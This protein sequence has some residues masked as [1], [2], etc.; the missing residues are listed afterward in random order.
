MIA[1]DRN[2]HNLAPRLLGVWTRFETIMWIFGH[3]VALTE[4]LRQRARQAELYAKGRTEL[5][6]YISE[7]HPKGLT[8]TN[9]RPGSSD[10]EPDDDGLGRAF[11]FHFISGGPAWGEDQ[12]WDLAGM[13]V[14]GLGVGWG[15]DW[16]SMNAGKGDR[17]HVYL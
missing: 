15:G 10:H 4:G 6:P 7:K 2:P 8:V 13:V 11:D 3:P 12:P 1:A 9:A 5:G 17:P 16:L 14:K